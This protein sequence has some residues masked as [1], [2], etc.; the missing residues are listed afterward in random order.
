MFM[1]LVSMLTIAVG[2]HTDAQYT[3][4]ALKRCNRY[5]LEH[6]LVCL[7]DI[8]NATAKIESLQKY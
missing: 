3:L 2:S 7:I 8:K 6:A 1:E 4:L 5:S